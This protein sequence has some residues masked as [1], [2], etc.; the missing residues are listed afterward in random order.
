MSLS[1]PLTCLL[2]GPVRNHCPTLTLLQTLAYGGCIIRQAQLQNVQLKMKMG[3][4]AD[5]HLTKCSGPC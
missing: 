3:A 1:L 4:L 2:Q 5:Q